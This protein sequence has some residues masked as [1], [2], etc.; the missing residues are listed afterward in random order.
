[1]GHTVVD[2]VV[3]IAV[4]EHVRL[5]LMLVTLMSLM[6]SVNVLGGLMMIF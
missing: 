1:M 5:R 6:M 2:I 4:L 3:L